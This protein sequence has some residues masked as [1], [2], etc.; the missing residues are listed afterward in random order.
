MDSELPFTLS[1]SFTQKK[2]FIW[3]AQ[4]PFMLPDIPDV[5]IT[6][7]LCM[8]A[9][10]SLTRYNLRKL[11][12]PISIPDQFMTPQLFSTLLSIYEE[13]KTDRL[14]P[15]ELCDI[16]PEYV[17]FDVNFMATVISLSRSRSRFERFERACEDV[18]YIVAKYIMDEKMINM[19][20]E[21]Y[22]ILLTKYPITLPM[23][24]DADIDNM[25]IQACKNMLKHLLL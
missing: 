19:D 22:Y 25:S 24:D 18:M 3:V 20:N 21:L 10:L 12:M 4:N 2:L 23:L 9:V 1:I 6:P 11:H 8:H 14:D 5:R 15:Y 17:G 16:Y 13:D 7:E